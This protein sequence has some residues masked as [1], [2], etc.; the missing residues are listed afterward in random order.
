MAGC[1]RPPPPAWN[2]G[3]FQ[4][5]P[6]PLP[7]PLSEGMALKESQGWRGAR[8]PQVPELPGSPGAAG[9]ASP[10]WK[11]GDAPLEHPDP[12]QHVL[13]AAMDL[14]LSREGGGSSSQEEAAGISFGCL[15]EAAVKGDGDGGRDVP[16][17]WWGL[18][19]K[20]PLNMADSW[21]SLLLLCRTWGAWG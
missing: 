2:K 15:G 14:P 18:L 12:Q 7:T 9:W 5:V 8:G 4:L 10:S 19:S 16:P 6:W 21:E 3:G 1:L 20:A 13:A 17:E 11:S